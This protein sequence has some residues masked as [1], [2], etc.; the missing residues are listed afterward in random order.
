MLAVQIWGMTDARAVAV[1]ILAVIVLVLF[2]LNQLFD[3]FG[4]R[5]PR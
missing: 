1:A 3:L 2:G 4:R 5:P